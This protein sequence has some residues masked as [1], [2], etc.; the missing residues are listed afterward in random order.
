[1]PIEKKTVR[2][3]LDAAQVLAEKS[4]R[5]GINAK[6]CAEA[7]EN[8]SQAALYAVQTEEILAKWEP[9]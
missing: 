4:Q 3:L 2:A 7:S 9:S 1:M 5:K 8:F 6:V